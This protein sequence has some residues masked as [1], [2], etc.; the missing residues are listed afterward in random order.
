MKLQ[1]LE[2]LAIHNRERIIKTET[3]IKHLVWINSGILI[4]VLI[5]LI[6]EILTK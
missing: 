6:K 1:E 3:H 4:T 2:K 5:H